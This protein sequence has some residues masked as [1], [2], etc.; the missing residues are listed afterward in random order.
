MPRQTLTKT[1]PAGPIPLT[2]ATVVTW[3]AAD[4]TNFE[5]VAL[6]GQD[7]VL[8]WNTHASTGYTYTV[9]TVADAMGRT[10]TG[11]GMSAVAL[12]AGVMH[13]FIPGV[14]GFG[15][16]GT[17]RYLYIQA[18]NASVKWAVLTFP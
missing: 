4:I 13:A 7:V 10:D 18:N 3:T 8:V 15:Q 12:A 16:A 17:P 1:A 9:T 14:E 5:Q 6:T 11:A 2:A